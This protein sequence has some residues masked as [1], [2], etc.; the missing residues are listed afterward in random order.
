M[1]KPGKLRC[2]Y[3][4]MLKGKR[5]TLDIESVR[6][7]PEKLYCSGQSTGAWDVIFTQHDKDGNNLYVQIPQPNIH[8]KRTS[9]LRQ[10]VM[11]T[12]GDP[13]E[14]SAGKKI[15][16]YPVESKKSVT[17][18]AIRIAIPEHHA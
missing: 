15:T 16:L 1:S 18:Q 12:G 8:G 10:F 5:I 9:L 14:E 17:G 2:I 11:A 7:A 3:A 4:E 6:E 13:S